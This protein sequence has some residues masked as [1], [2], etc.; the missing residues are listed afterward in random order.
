M[1]NYAHWTYTGQRVSDLLT[2]EKSQIRLNENGT[3][4]ID[5]IQQ[6]KGTHVTV[7]IGDSLVK[8]I[9]FLLIFLKRPIPKSSIST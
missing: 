2:I 4:Y 7:A 6:K 8:S 9:S 3:L 5:F 1:E